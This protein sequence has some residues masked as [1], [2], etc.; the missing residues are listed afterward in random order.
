VSNRQLHYQQPVSQLLPGN[1][2]L[3]GTALP[4]VTIE[5][6]SLAA[7]AEFIVNGD[8]GMPFPGYVL[9]IV[10]EDTSKERTASRQSSGDLPQ[11]SPERRFQTF[12]A[13]A[14][15]DAQ[16]LAGLF[17]VMSSLTLQVMRLIQQEMLPES[18]QVALAEVLLSGLMT[19]ANHDQEI[20]PDNVP[21]AFIPEIGERLVKTAETPDL[22][23]IFRLLSARITRQI[24]H[25]TDFIS[26]LLDNDA[27]TGT[28]DVASQPFAA[29][30]LAT[31]RQLGGE[32]ARIAA[33][34][35]Q[36]DAL[37]K[38]L[39]SVR[40]AA[41]EW[42]EDNRNWRRLQHKPEELT[43]LLEILR[44]SNHL[45]DKLDEATRE[46][47]RACEA[48]PSI[49]FMELTLTH[50]A[51]SQV[52]VYCNGQPS[53]TFDLRALAPDPAIPDRPPQPL[54]DP[55]AYGQALYQALFPPQS[56]AQQA[57]ASRPERMLLV[58]D[59]QTDAVPWEY[60]YGPDGFLVLDV[61]LVRGLPADQ[62]R[63]LPDLTSGLHIVAVPSNPLDP[64]V[65]PL[66]IDGEWQ[67]LKDVI[68]QVPAA[69]TLERVRPPTLEQLRRLIAGQQQCV[70]HF[71][72]HGGTSDDG[73][74]LCF[75]QGDGGLA[76]VTA[77]DFLRRTKGTTFL[78]TLN[79]NVTAT[80]GETPF[81]NLAAA[82]VRQG[83]PYALGMRFVVADSD[84]R[85]LSRIFYSELARGSSVEEAVQQVRLE[86]AD[87]PQPWAVGVPVL[88][89]SL[90]DPAAG[91]APV[92]GQP[93]ISEHQPPLELFS[94]PRAEGTFQGRQAE[95]RQIGSRLTGDNRPRLLTIHGSGGQGKTA[96]AREAVERF[97]HAF[98]GGVVA[99]SLE[100]LPAREQIVTML[101]RFLGIDTETIADPAEL[102]RQM[103]TRLEQRLTLLVLDNADTL[104]Q[105]AQAGEAE[106]LRL[107]Q[108]LREQMPA[109]TTLLIT[110]RV[111][112]GW[113]GEEP[114][115]LGGLDHRHG[116]RLF[117]QYATQRAADI[118]LQQ[119]EDLSEKVNGHPLSLRLLGSAF[120][121]LK[122]SLTDFVQN[123]KEYPLQSED[124]YRPLDQRHRSL[125]QNID[126]SV[127]FLDDDLRALLGGL[128]LF[129]APFL[130][131]MAV[132]LFDPD[133][134]YP[135]GERSPVYD[136]LHR[137]LLRS[138][139]EVE[140]ATTSEGRLLFYR[141]HPTV[142][143]FAEQHMQAP[144]GRAD[145][146]TRFGT[147]YAGLARTL[148]R[149]I[150]R[151]A[152]L[153]VVAQVCAGDL[154]RGLE[155]APAEQQGWYALHRGWVLQRLGD[156]QR[157]L[158]LT[159]QA[160]AAGEHE[161]DLKLH[162]LNNMAAVYDATGQ[163][164]RALAL[165]EEALPLMRAV[166]DRAGEAITL[167]NMALVYNYTGQPQ[168]AL[169]LYE[170]ALPIMRAVGDR[171]SEA[172]TLNNMGEVYRATGH[173]QRALALYEEA[174]PIMRAVGDRASE[175]ATLNNM[176]EV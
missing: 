14:S 107:A 162:A 121:E 55:V 118:H 23:H 45:L 150:D 163:P 79:T 28:V 123:Y 94:L 39:A 102:E 7:W 169:A 12:V 147:A 120:N 60:L 13:S 31:L 4:V 27:L 67:R 25:P 101:A 133:G 53:H 75:E 148:Y 154:D 127:R 41:K 18:R 96:L 77:R 71:M 109:S 103:L 36:N 173:P 9:D 153:V 90:S 52:N 70:I 47:I 146:L 29:L 92:E 61:T 174:L 159:E 175:A 139:L 108:L 16:R 130:P 11:R 73:A 129:H 2:K 115:P 132:A 110:S 143:L 168:R 164:Q 145:L 49:R 161:Q 15:P 17:A 34:A 35:E 44:D 6:E 56:P 160:R 113:G 171:A 32:F 138:L 38:L 37:A 158:A 30:S 114:L 131:E 119:A 8:R 116:A 40:K 136:Q 166:S 125:Y 74:V 86:L 22:R 72:G 54:A 3:A 51:D 26:Y 80:P 167:N 65:L 33:Q 117:S 85:T 46:Y 87:S 144:D 124:K 57:L 62:R 97:A 91:F 64:G 98:P 19:R 83:T 5:P 95:L 105:A 165:Y 137:L 78:V 151:S 142:R 126:F 112:L 84:A 100:S 106:A 48:D 93:R 66:N 157:G 141:L 104:T 43:Q 89:T 82:L 69:L 155:H 149:G 140:T 156:R 172:A 99:V 68:Q 134:E 21:Y 76:N 42:E 59:E 176:G 10:E 111:F 20:D 170:E 122:T 58:T 88:Y 50:Q 24:G 63:A 81:A 1:Q 135:E 128:W 152:E